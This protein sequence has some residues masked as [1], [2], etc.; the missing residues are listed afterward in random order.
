MCM[1]EERA[2]P[3][4]QP[5]PFAFFFAMFASFS[6]RNRASKSSFGRAA[7]AGAAVALCPPAWGAARLLAGFGATLPFMVPFM[8]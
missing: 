7:G 4:G 6:A 3:K 2:Y 8:P 1:L 5:P